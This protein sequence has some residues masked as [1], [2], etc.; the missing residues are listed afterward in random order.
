MLR[1]QFGKEKAGQ[2]GQGQQ[3]N[4]PEWELPGMTR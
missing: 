4:L 3:R 2:A 1:Q